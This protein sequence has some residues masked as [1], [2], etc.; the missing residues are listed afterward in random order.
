MLI[1]AMQFFPPLAFF[2][3]CD[4]TVYKSLLIET[5]TNTI[6]F[7]RFNPNTGERT[8]SPS[9]VKSLPFGLVDR[10]VI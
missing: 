4:F 7:H 5:D 6:G 1:K 10:K 8:V 2:T 3:V 9:L